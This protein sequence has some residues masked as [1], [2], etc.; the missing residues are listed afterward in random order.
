MTKIRSVCATVILILGFGA[1]LTTHAQSGCDPGTIASSCGCS[2]PGQT[3]TPPC[4]LAQ[5]AADFAPVSDR[6]Q[7]PASDLGSIASA[8]VEDILFP[9]L[10]L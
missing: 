8:V 2:A 1:A 10:M 5:V 3:Q 4:A 7:P 9:L 6:A